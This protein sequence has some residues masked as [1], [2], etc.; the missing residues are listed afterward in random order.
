MLLIPEL[1]IVVILPPRTGS[2]TLRRALAAKYPKTIALYRHMEADGVPHGYTH[3]TKVGF[4]RDPMERLYS[5]WKF[6]KNPPKDQPEAWR[7]RLM[8]SVANYK[9]FYRWVIHNETPFTNQYDS[10]GDGKLFP[11]FTVLHSMPEN[12]KPQAMYLREDL[13]TKVFLFEAMDRVVKE[14]FDIDL[15]KCPRSN[16]SEGPEHDPGPVVGMPGSRVDYHLLNQVKNDL[17]QFKD[18]VERWHVADMAI[19]D[20]LFAKDLSLYTVVCDKGINPQ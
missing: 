8:N 9:T 13:G 3:W 7:Q 5:L 12:I 19:R 6:C 15:T 4:I 20:R 11:F 10:T 1:E 17:Y 2:G 14:V 18:H 16:V